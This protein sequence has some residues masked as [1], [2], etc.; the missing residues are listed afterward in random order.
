MTH[1]LELGYLDALTMSERFRTRDLSPVEV[2]QAVTVL[3]EAREPYLNAFHVRSREE[4]LEQARASEKRWR[5]GEPLSSLDG[6]PITLKENIARVGVAMTAGNAGVTP[7]YPETSAPTTVRVENAGMVVLGST[8]MPDWG[9]LSSGVSS[10]HG[11][12]RSPLDLGWTTGGS[13]S[14]AAAAAGGGYGPLHIGSDIGGSI[15]LPSSWVGLCGLKPSFGRIPSDTPYFARTIGPMARSVGELAAVMGIVA[16]FDPVDFTALPPM[17]VDWDH[18][19]WDPRR[20]RVGLHLDAGCGGDTDPA[21]LAAVER[22]AQHFEDAG[23]VVEIVPAF[24]SQEL[25]G[26]LDLFWRVRSWV[27]Y[28]HLNPEAR[29]RVLPYVA[30]WCTGGADTS[31]ADLLR[32]YQATMEIQRRTVLVTEPYDIVLSPVSPVAAFPAEQPMP[33]EGFNATMHH[34]GYTAPY[35]MSGQPAMSVNCGFTDD[36]RPIGVQISG[37]RFDDPGVLR[38]ANWYEQSRPNAA[39]PTFPHDEVIPTSW[40]SFRGQDQDSR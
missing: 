19:G 2:A 13:S 9:M 15:R 34:I 28:R 27:D 4:A 16:G 11:I 5:N 30:N 33:Y 3:I 7:L 14:G 25:L 32:C 35:S 12:T 6:V 40:S 37:R 8:V 36:G 38:A 18:T 29:N 21:V 17:E 26:A 23:A 31:G 22:C 1:G 10:L 39:A 24:M 20:R